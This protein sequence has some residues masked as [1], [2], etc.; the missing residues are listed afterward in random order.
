METDQAD[1][2]TLEVLQEALAKAMAMSEANREKAN[3]FQREM[4]SVEVVCSKLE[5][6]EENLLIWAL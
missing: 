1:Q 5:I 6:W 2:A 4:E 3:Q